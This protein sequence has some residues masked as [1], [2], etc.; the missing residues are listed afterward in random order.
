MR[1][2]ACKWGLILR[3]KLCV[4]VCVCVCVSGLILRRKLCVC[5]CV[6][7]GRANGVSISDVRGEV[8]ERGAVP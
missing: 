7:A 3:R 2:R 4:C 6:Y 8:L 1:L 5:V